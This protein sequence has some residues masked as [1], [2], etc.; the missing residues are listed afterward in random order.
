MN[1]NDIYSMDHKGLF[2]TIRGSCHSPNIS[3]GAYE[4]LQQQWA[5]LLKAHHPNSW[6]ER[7]L[8]QN[9]A[10]C[11]QFESRHHQK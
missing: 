11:M 7:V 5:S 9:L 8:I 2:D 1:R 4:T 6:A 10:F 3:K